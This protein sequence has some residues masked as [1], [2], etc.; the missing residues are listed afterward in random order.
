MLL[1]SD[2]EIRHFQISTFSN[3][4]IIRLH[5]W[6][7]IDILLLQSNHM[8]TP[9][10]LRPIAFIGR[11]IRLFLRRLSARPSFYQFNGKLYIK[12]GNS[13]IIGGKTLPGY[14]PEEGTQQDMKWMYTSANQL[15][16]SPQ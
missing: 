15:P 2:S 12:N 4:Q 10:S 7:N 8:K 5:F 14:E 13:R 9:I 11:F 1:V 16:Y 3:F 6:P